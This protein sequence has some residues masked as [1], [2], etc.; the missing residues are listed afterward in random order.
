MNEVTST[1]FCWL[2]QSLESGV[3]KHM[4]SLD[5]K[6]GKDELQKGMDTKKM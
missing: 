5:V 4:P 3:G 1:I 6:R 2:K